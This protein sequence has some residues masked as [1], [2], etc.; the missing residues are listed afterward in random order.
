ERTNLLMIAGQQLATADN[1]RKVHGLGLVLAK[2]LDYAGHV[3]D[4]ERF[5]QL[6]VAAA[7]R[8]GDRAGTA[9]ARN[10]LAIA[11]R[12]RN[13]LASG[14]AVLERA[15]AMHRELGDRAGEAACLNNLGNA[16]RDSG[17]LETALPYL[18]ETLA[19]RQSLHDRYKVGSTLDNIGI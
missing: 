17:D 7:E 19:I 16:Y 15:L 13:Q 14:I 1:L 2:Y 11:R 4:Q 9:K 18:R 5:G 8:L 3:S 10:A 12:R 6:S